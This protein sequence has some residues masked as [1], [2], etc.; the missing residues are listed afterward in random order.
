MSTRRAFLLSTAAFAAGTSAVQHAGRAS[1]PADKPSDKPAGKLTVRD[2]RV[3][4]LTAKADPKKKALFVEVVADNGL[5][6]WAGAI[7]YETAVIVGRRLRPRVVGADALAHEAVWDAMKLSDRH[8]RAGHYM[9][10]ISAVD[11]ALWDL[12]GKHL[13]LPVYRLLGG[14]TRPAVPV[15]ASL[16]GYSTEP[17]AARKVAREYFDKGFTF[18]K[19]FFDH[20]PGEGSSGF[21]KNVAL[22][23][24]LRDELGPDAELM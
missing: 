11:I 4:E 18:Q 12:R 8:S 3:H 22:V 24:A 5:S 14:P 7:F 20:G 16:L 13:G 1:L 9:M 10:A 2:V 19:W 17:A 21:K 6:G 23:K 15:Y